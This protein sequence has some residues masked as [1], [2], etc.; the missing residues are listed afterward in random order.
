MR[1]CQRPIAVIV[2]T[3][4]AAVVSGCK[5]GGGTGALAGG[6]I[7]AIAGQVIG[8]NTEATLIGTAVGTGVGYII[9]NEADKAKAQRLS[10][11]SA[12]KAAATHNEVGPL[13]GSRWS[14]AS[15]SPANATPAYKSKVIEF[16][17]DGRAITITTKE[18]GSV[19]TADESYR[20]VGDTLIVNKPG[21]IINAKYQR[22]GN[23]LVVTADKFSAVLQKL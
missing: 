3:A 23:Q 22:N 17:P 8:G 16:R 1:A 12:E 5:T 9:G 18:D 20:V 13:G 10:E 11:Q 6:G 4:F 15:L 19:E 21:Y 14:L 7:G 2:L